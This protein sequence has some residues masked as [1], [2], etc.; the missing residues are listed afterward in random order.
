MKA[1]LQRAV[2]AT[3]MLLATIMAHAYEFEVDGIYYHPISDTEVEVISGAW[4]NPYFGKVTIPSTVTFSSKTYSV[5]SIGSCAF[6]DC[7]GLTSIKL[8]NSVTSIGSS[9]FSRCSSLTSMEFPNS[10][11]SIKFCAFYGCSSLT[12]IEF[13]NT[14][15]S[16][17][18]DAFAACP[19]IESITVHATEPPAAHIYAF[20]SKIYSTSTLNVPAVAYDLYKTAPVWSNWTTINS[21][22]GSGVADSFID[23]DVKIE[24]G[25]GAITVS[26]AEGGVCRIFDLRGM[27]VSSRTGLSAHESFTVKSPELY[28]VQV[29][30]DNGKNTIRKFM[31]K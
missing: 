11:T 26:G 21:I 24:V 30:N 16:I 9:A 7:T 28:I 29:S 3:V 20:E 31:V 25:N 2:M 23:S 18:N 19:Q 13:P 12:S 22:G 1:F 8:P 4:Y 17:G 6:K 15:T 27:E 5:T 10:I 14:L